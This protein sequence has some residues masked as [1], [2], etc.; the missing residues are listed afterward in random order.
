MESTSHKPNRGEEWTEIVEEEHRNRSRS[1]TQHRNRSRDR[2]RRAL[3][4]GEEEEEEK[5]RVKE[6]G[7]AKCHKNT[8]VFQNNLFQS[9]AVLKVHCKSR[10]DDLGDHFVNFQGP[11]YDFRFGDNIFLTTKWHCSLAKG[12]NPQ[13]S[14]EFQA[15][16]GAPIFRRCS[17]VYAW[18]ARDDGIYLSKN[19]E[20]LQ[21]MYSWDKI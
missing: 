15:Y 3:G 10:D 19:R 14:R 4:G 18:E 5:R 1:E 11:G 21:L 12:T 8:L 2:R 9:H 13:Y 6:K 17:A 20:P 16:E 7:E